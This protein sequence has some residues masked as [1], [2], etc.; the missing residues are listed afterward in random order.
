[1]PWLRRLAQGVQSSVT[2]RC[3]VSQYRLA[4]TSFRS[5]YRLGLPLFAPPT[6]HPAKAGRR[7]LTPAA[8]CCAK[9]PMPV[10]YRN[11]RGIVIFS[12]SIPLHGDQQAGAIMRESNSEGSPC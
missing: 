11:E 5:V 3:G 1:E 10:R 2:A 6:A 8:F 7:P 9:G 12:R 4:N